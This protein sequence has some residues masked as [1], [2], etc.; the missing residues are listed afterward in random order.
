MTTD[1]KQN[2]KIS[3]LE[4]R[5]EVT[6]I[7]FS[8][9]MENLKEIMRVGFEHVTEAISRF[10]KKTEEN[11][12]ELLRFNDTYRAE[13]ENKYKQLD[14]KIAD[15][16]RQAEIVANSLKREVAKINVKIAGWGGGL[17]VILYIIDKFVK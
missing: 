17:A 4:K 8:K 16:E 12:K 3:E 7:G 15:V 9:D 5:L 10:E 14:K 6:T 1:S 11:Q 2:N 13:C